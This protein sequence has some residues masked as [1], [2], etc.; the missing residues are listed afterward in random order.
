MLSG[1]TVE[2]K[3]QVGY[4]RYWSLDNPSSVFHGVGYMTERDIASSD[5][6]QGK[7]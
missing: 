6:Q 7:G 3:A 1:T 4:A 2:L 5:A